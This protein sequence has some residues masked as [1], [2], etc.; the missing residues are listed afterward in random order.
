MTT[1]HVGAERDA[2]V[3][4]LE[5]LASEAHALASGIHAMEPDPPEIARRIRATRDAYAAVVRLL[6]TWSRKAGL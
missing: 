3:R 2:V 6:G 4:A 1:R 5:Q